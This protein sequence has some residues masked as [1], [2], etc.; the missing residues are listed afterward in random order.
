MKSTEKQVK[1]YDKN[2]KLIGVG[3]LLSIGSSVIKVKGNDLPI[4][5]S[6]SEINIEIYNEFSGIKPYY[7]KV[8]LASINQLNA[9][10]LRND[11][12]IER[13]NS[14][15]VRTDLSLYID[16]LYR[17]D[18]DVT[19]N[20]PNLEITILNLSIGGM[21]I[22]SNY[23]LLINDIIVFKFQYEKYQVIELKAKVIRIDKIYDSYTKELS[24]KNYGCMFKKLNSYNESVITKYL[25]DRQLQLYKN[26]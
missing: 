4:L 18:E 25:Y 23:D 17:N 9:M 10:I 1:I 7:C 13:R 2:K 19:E 12:I 11:P 6:G 5:K 8:S 21:M 15:K 24:A 14:L 20:V 26:R 22:S 16:Y 3:M